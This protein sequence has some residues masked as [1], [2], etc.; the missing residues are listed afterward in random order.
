MLFRSAESLSCSTWAVCETAWADAMR[1]RRDMSDAMA[2]LLAVCA[3]TQQGG[4]QLFLDL[5]G[6]PGS[7][8]TTMCQGLLVSSHCVH[9]EH[10]TKLVSGFKKPGDGGKDCSFLARSNKKTWVTCEFD[11]LG[12]SPEYHQLMGKVRRIF[13]GETSTTYGNSDEEIGRASCRERV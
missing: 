11:V 13:D 1:W 10:V 5:I 8:K 7:A 6:S 9:L 4:N 2:V 12:S 3:S